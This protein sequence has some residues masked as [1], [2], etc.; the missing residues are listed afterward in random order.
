L[1]DE[2]G[3]TALWFSAMQGNT[4][5]A[6]ILLKRGAQIDLGKDNEGITTLQ[7]CI[8]NGHLDTASLFIANGANLEAEDGQGIVIPKFF[9]QY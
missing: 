9:L 6:V 7:K 4:A 2:E 8:A 5:A 1:K 3:R